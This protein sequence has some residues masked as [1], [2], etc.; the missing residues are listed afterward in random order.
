MACSHSGERAGGRTGPTAD[1]GNQSGCD[2]W[3]RIK[4]PRAEANS[5]NGLGRGRERTP[6]W[7][8][9]R[10]PPRQFRRVTLRVPDLDAVGI[11]ILRNLVHGTD[12]PHRAGFLL[13]AA[14]QAFDM[15]QQASGGQGGEVAFGEFRFGGA[16]LFAEFLQTRVAGGEVFVQALLPLDG[17]EVGDGVLVFVTQAMSVGLETLSSAAIRVNTQP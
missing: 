4:D 7:E 9:G 14:L 2:W 13:Q 17:G 1:G 6:G 10:S 8:R 3:K 5:V 16:E 15:G 11:F 12:E